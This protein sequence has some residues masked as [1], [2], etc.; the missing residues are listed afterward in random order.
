MRAPR[1][2]TNHANGRAHRRM[3]TCHQ[4]LNVGGLLVC[5]EDHRP[6]P[7]FKR[8]AVTNA[9]KLHIEATTAYSQQSMQTRIQHVAVP[10]SDW[11]GH[12]I[13]SHRA[14]RHSE[15]VLRSDS[16]HKRLASGSMCTAP[17]ILERPHNTTNNAASHIE[18]NC[19]HHHQS[20]CLNNFAMCGHQG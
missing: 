18:R 12:A 9:V 3:P 20:C 6:I 19:A 1:L 11:G 4:L 5:C 16:H 15:G 2:S 14:M 7:T 8:R 17:Q 10:T 13:C